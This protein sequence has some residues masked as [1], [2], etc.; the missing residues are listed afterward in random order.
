MTKIEGLYENLLMYQNQRRVMARVLVVSFANHVVSILV[1]YAIALSLPGRVT[2]GYFFLLIPIAYVLATV[3]ITVGGMGVLEGSMVYLFSSVGM[4][5]ETCVS[6][7]VCQ[8]VMRMAASLPGGVIYLLNGMGS[9]ESREL[10]RSDSRAV[11]PHR[12]WNRA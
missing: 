10:H 9:V 1:Y 4:P 7:V 11:R 3:P 6:M 8:R 2:I 5:V 12:F